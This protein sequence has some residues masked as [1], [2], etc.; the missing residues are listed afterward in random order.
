MVL[1]TNKLV[2]A[3]FIPAPKLT[4]AVPVVCSQI[5][6][7]CPCIVVEISTDGMTR[8]V[9]TNDVDVMVVADAAS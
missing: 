2:G 1:V 4:V 9:V 3:K 8:P 6:A 5:I 7:Q